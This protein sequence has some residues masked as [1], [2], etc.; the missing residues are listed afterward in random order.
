MVLI[1][2]G[3]PVAAAALLFAL[4]RLLMNEAS[5]CLFTTLLAITPD[6][7]PILGILRG[8]TFVLNSAGSSDSLIRPYEFWKFST[9][10]SAFFHA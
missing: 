1:Y 7:S 4:R 3:K 2:G 9:A 5:L 6:M 10:S 8:F